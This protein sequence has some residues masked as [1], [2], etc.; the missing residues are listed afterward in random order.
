MV[1]YD[2]GNL[3]GLGGIHHV[4]MGVARVG[5]TVGFLYGDGVDLED[6]EGFAVVADDRRVATG[7]DLD[8]SLN[9][10]VHIGGGGGRANQGQEESGISKFHHA[11]ILPNPT[12]MYSSKNYLSR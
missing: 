6:T 2:L 8:E 9:Q 1:Q 5:Q 10:L 3:T 4:R 7:F 12:K 11:T